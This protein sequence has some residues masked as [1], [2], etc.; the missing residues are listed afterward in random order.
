MALTRR[1]FAGS[2]LT[3]AAFGS[4]L[5]RAQEYKIGRADIKL[6]V[7]SYSFRK[8]D[9]AQAIAMTKQLGTPYINVKDFHLPLNSTPE[10]I[11]AARKEITDAGLIIDG[12]GNVSFQKDDP[13]QM[14][15]KFEYARRL[16]APVIV[17]APKPEQLRDLEKLVKEFD[18]KIAIHNHGPE[19]PYFP[20]PQ[21]V[22]QAV[23]DLDPRCGWCM[24]VGHSVRTGADPIASVRQAGPRLLAMHMKDLADLMKK[25]S[26]VPVGRGKIP[27]AGIFN[28]LVRLGY[29]DS[30]D[31]EYEIDENNPMPGMVESFAYM[32]GALAGLEA[33]HS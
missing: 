2:A 5:A 7:A 30:V 24:D 9:R 31:L 16:G 13:A 29:R 19:D 22:L 20:S 8:F 23:K 21:S 25:D 1:G 15:P 14:R 12:I 4:T 32:R 10:Q 17:C 6:G 27:I 28:E 3:A 33:A 18:I 26:Q 11:D